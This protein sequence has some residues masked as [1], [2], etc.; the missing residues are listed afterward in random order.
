MKVA[1]KQIF[2]NVDLRRGED[3]LCQVTR[4]AHREALNVHEVYL[5]MNRRRNILK[6]VGRRGAFIDRL[7]N[8]QTYDFRLRRDQ[9]LQAVGEYFGLDFDIPAG[10]YKTARKTAGVN[11]GGDIH[12]RKD[13]RVSGERAGSSAA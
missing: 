9:I 6:V 7:P 2:Q 5:F 1:I 11:E 13:S 12:G 3:G 10:V 4:G 8:P